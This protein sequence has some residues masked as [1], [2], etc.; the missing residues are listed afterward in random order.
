MHVGRY[1]RDEHLVGDIYLGWPF[2]MRGYGRESVAD[3]VRAQPA[4][5][6]R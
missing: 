1:G 4:G 5:G 2:L 3:G 6:R